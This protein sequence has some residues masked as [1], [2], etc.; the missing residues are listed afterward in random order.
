MGQIWAE[1]NND[2]PGATV[3]FTIPAIEREGQD[4]KIVDKSRT[5]NILLIDDEEVSYSSL[6]LLLY[7]KN[8][9]ISAC[10]SGHAALD[11]LNKNSRQVDL[12]ML[13]LIM[14]D[15]HGLDILKMIKQ[16]NNIC[17]IPVLI[18][19]GVAGNSE[20]TQAMELGAVDNIEKPF[21]MRLL[22]DKINSIIGK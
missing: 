8:F 1:N 10:N 13:D 12:I 21:N 19:S 7:G 17:H 18:Q 4:I 16:N 6:S 5:I 11:Y 2:G 9:N 3:Y 14:P 15:I 20:I 22:L